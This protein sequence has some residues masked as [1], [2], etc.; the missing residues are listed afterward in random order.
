MTRLTSSVVS[1]HTTTSGS[2]GG[3][4]DSSCEASSRSAGLVETRSGDR[5]AAR[6]PMRLIIPPSFREEGGK[7]EEG[8]KRKGKHENTPPLF[9]PFI[10]L[11][12][13]PFTLLLQRCL[14]VSAASSAAEFSC[15][16]GST[17][18]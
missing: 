9:L 16:D 17:A 14:S 18:G 11:L 5:I 4:D 6:L 8:K 3:H 2:E 12:S 13:C 1:G 10:L 7:G 15:A